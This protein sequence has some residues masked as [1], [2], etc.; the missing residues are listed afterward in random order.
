MNGD[1]KNFIPKNN[2]QFFTSAWFI[3]TEVRYTP[4]YRATATTEGTYGLWEETLSL[5]F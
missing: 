3:N 1:R 4:E 2:Q 5:A